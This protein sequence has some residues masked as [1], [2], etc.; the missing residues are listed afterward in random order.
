MFGADAST[1]VC[2]MQMCFM[3]DRSA[4]KRKRRSLVGGRSIWCL[5]C[6]DLRFDGGTL[7]AL[8]VAGESR[9][10]APAGHVRCRSETARAPGRRETRRPRGASNQ[11]ALQPGTHYLQL[12]CVFAKDRNKRSRSRKK[13]T[14]CLRAALSVCCSRWLTRSSYISLQGSC[15]T[16]Q[17]EVSVAA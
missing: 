10:S 6:L 5:L 15:Q 17:L 4:S 1:V 2:R 12:F 11:S 9:Q 3:E 8:R 13:A 14:L 16:F 7:P